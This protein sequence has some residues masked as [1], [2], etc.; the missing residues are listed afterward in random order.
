MKKLLDLMKQAGI[1]EDGK[2][3]LYDGRTGEPFDGRISVG[4]MYML[5]LAHMVDDKLT[6]SCYWSLFTCYTTTFRW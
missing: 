5:K 2:T 4:V 3:I 1:A 6:C